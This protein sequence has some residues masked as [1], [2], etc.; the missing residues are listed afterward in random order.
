MTAVAVPR[1]YTLIAELTYRCPLRCVYCS[2]PRDADLRAQD[3][4][5]AVWLRA[6][7]EAKQLGVWHLHLTG[8]EPLLR[9]DLEVLVA[10]A[11][12]VGLYVNL[13]TSG[14][15]LD[16]PRLTELARVGLEHLQLSFQGSAAAD[17]VDF[18]GVAAFE[19]KIE[20][21]GWA[22]S[23]GLPL[24]LNFVL[25]RGNIDRI[26]QMLE[27]ADR[28]GADRVELANTQYLGWAFVNRRAL[29]PSSEQVAVARALVK[30]VRLARPERELVF[31]LPD[32]RAGRA[33]ACMDG[34]ANRY[35][36]IDPTG[37]VLP[38]HSAR[39]IPG[40]AFESVADTPLASIW[41][42]SPGLLEFRGEA[43]LPDAC[44]S[45]PGRTQ[46]HGGCRCQAYAL[47][48]DARAVDP[49]CEHAPAH[50]RVRELE[51]APLVPLRLRRL[52]ADELA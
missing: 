4:D 16:R 1:P 27:L 34:W 13:I 22:K 32:Y 45:C 21:A 3:L 17:S 30:R 35:I 9:R 2:N 7:A 10:G 12:D 19:R 47:T 50:E 23:L 26:E 51:H 18:A 28:L 31:V 8:G 40:L 6:F 24:T 11:R 14:V 43:G 46:D 44:R 42:H 33:R 20:V 52:G 29:L 39:S 38:C 25:H 41:A 49:A 48:G 36:V 37:A 15:P 5:T